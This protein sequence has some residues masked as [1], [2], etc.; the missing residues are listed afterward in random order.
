MKTSALKSRL[1]PGRVYRRQELEPYSS[2][3]N[4]DLQALMES[5]LL[6]KAYY[7]IYYCPERSRFGELPP[8]DHALIR[9]FLKTD[10]FLAFSPNELNHLGLGATQLLNVTR[11][12]NHKRHGLYTLAGQ[13][14]DFRLRPYFPKQLT[15]EFLFVE[16]LNERPFLAE[17]VP[18]RPERLQAK[19]QQ[20]NKQRLV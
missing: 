11:V 4:R 8:K 14:F 3:L 20:L 2:N 1:R 15:E 12:Y 9:A 13:T 7:G 19:L 6:K 17:E 10:D 16:F 5:G 18:L